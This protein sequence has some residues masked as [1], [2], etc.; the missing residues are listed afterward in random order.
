MIQFLLRVDKLFLEKVATPLAHAIQRRYGIVSYEL[1]SMC[2]QISAAAYLFSNLHEY[3]I[4]GEKIGW[5]SLMDGFPLIWFGLHSYYLNRHMQRSDWWKTRPA[6]TPIDIAD[7]VRGGMLCVAMF[8]TYKNVEWLATSLS[9]DPYVLRQGVKKK[10]Y[11]VD[12]IMTLVMMW[13]APLGFYFASVPPMPPSAPGKEEKDI[14]T[15]DKT[16]LESNFT[17]HST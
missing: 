11:T 3:F 13:T 8:A 15:F 1:A 5:W 16:A 4:Q 6:P 12:I 7:F 2:M 14:S 9:D 10:M 17:A